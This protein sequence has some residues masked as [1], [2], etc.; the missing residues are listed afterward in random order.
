MSFDP[1]DFT[2]LAFGGAGP[3]HA[4]PVA[5]ELG[6]KEILIPFFPGIG[7]QSAKGLTGA[8]Y[9]VF[10]ILLIY[11]MP[12]G[13]AGLLRLVVQRIARARS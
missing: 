13:A 9:G 2:L 12:S 4:R 8:V 5:V 7:E 11:V 10:L 6:I 1:R 3:L